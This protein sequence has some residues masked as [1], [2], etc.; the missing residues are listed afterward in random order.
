MT[1]TKEF[2]EQRPRPCVTCKKLTPYLVRLGG[3][4]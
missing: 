2:A 4:N 1:I 3:D